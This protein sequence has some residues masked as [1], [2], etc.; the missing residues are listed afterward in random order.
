VADLAVV[1]AGMMGANH[2]RTA[3]SSRLWDRVL[4]VDADPV[5]AET[6]G[7]AHGIAWTSD[8]SSVPGEVDA[9]VVAVTTAAHEEVTAPLLAAGTHLLV[10]KPLAAT[11][12]AARRI[13]AAAAASGSRVLVGHI[14][15]FN[16]AVRELM[17]LREPPLHVEFR[18]VGPRSSRALG[19]VVSDLMVHDLEVFL[20]LTGGE[21][22]HVAAITAG[23]GAE[24]DL[25]VALLRSSTGTTATVTA[26]RVGQTKHRSVVVTA[27]D[28]QVVADLVRQQ[29]TVHRIDHVEFVDDRGPRYRQ[30]GT[31]EI[32]YLEHGEPLLHEHRH[33][34]DVVAGLA[35]PLVGT[36]QAIRA[37][38]LVERV[39][40]AAAGRP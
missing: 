12:E 11:P 31:T 22:E 36:A 4:V 21:V 17:A 9:A 1:G 8:A 19:D 25:C 14:E 13:A 20:A 39:R 24:E 40:R 15:R 16:P 27:H 35:E 7:R 10:E 38:D 33:F 29:V 18:R 37:L 30:R 26:S 34:A 2:V 5:R 32:P 23:Q 3:L 6:L 28:V